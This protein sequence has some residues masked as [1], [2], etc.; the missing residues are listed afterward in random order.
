LQRRTEKKIAAATAIVHPVYIVFPVM[1][2]L[3]IFATMAPWLP[4]WYEKPEV[5]QLLAIIHQHFF[6]RYN[7]IICR[8]HQGKCLALAHAATPLGRYPE[9]GLWGEVY[10]Q[11]VEQ[12][13][14]GN[15]LG[16]HGDAI[17]EKPL[18]ING[19]PSGNLT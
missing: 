12:K 11:C 8:S 1:I 3:I 7:V 18:G 5:G 2:C 17:F 14:V 19:I 16:N 6:P 13:K 10:R 4:T 15:I 9:G